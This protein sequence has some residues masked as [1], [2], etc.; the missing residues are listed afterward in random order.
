VRISD[1]CKRPQPAEAPFPAGLVGGA[2]PQ[3]AAKTP[4]LEGAAGPSAGSED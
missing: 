1:A 2:S 3:E 4:M